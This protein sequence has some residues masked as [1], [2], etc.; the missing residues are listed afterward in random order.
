MNHTAQGFR[1]RCFSEIK[2]ATDRDRIHRGNTDELSQSTRKSRDPVLRIKLALMGIAC[3]AV[4]AEGLAPQ[5]MAIQTLIDND[6]IAPLQIANF[7]ADFFDAAADLMSQDLRI[8]VEWNRLSVLIGVVVRVAG[9]DMSIGAAQANRRNA[10]NDCM[11][12]ADRRW[13]V[14]NFQVLDATQVAC[15]HSGPGVC[16]RKSLFEC[17]NRSTQT[18]FPIAISASMSFVSSRPAS[19]NSRKRRMVSR[20]PISSGVFG[21]SPIARLIAESSSA[22]A[23][24]I[25]GPPKLASSRPAFSLIAAAIFFTSTVSPC[26]LK[27]CA[28]SGPASL[29]RMKAAAVSSTY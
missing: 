20:T 26:R 6:A 12:F 8:D 29:Q 2:A 7:A 13:Y 18:V 14:A 3:A 9:K 25:S 19:R 16:E 4:L 24:G 23:M 17:I 11:R 28:P 21:N 22:G 5:A 1:H 27:T 15:A 10:H